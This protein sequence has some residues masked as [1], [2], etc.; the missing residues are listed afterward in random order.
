MSIS[1][2]RFNHSLL[3]SL[4]L[5]LCSPLTARAALVEGQDWRAVSPAQPSDQ[6]GMIEVLEFFSYGCSHCMTF[7]PIVKEWARDLPPDV[8]FRRIPVT[9]G[10]TAWKNLARLFHALEI[11]GRLDQLDQAA[12]DALHHER[13]RLYTREAILDWGAEHD[14]ERETFAAVYDSFD[15][16]TRLARSE[17]LAERY[18]INAVPTLSVGGRYVVLGRHAKG[19][20]GLLDIAD[21]L[22]VQ[23]RSD[24]MPA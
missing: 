15:L 20:E 13:K 1:R 12:F 18:Q 17:Q 14:I 5:A 10:R 7:N 11:S 22:I 19:F 4:S 21:E 2:R 8:A 16:Q 3:A 23:V 24:S 9:F 6:P